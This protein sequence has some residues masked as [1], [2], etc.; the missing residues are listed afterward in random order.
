MSQR[1]QYKKK[2]LLSK[3]GSQMMRIDKFGET[4]SFSIAGRDSYPSF[5]GTLI[6]IMVLSVVI[7]YGLNKYLIMQEYEDTSFQ[8]IKVDNAIGIREEFGY[9]QTNL[10]YFIFFTDST[11]LP[12]P[13][14]DLEGY[15]ELRGVE[16]EI[17]KSSTTNVN[18]KELNF[19]P[20]TKNDLKTNFFPSHDSD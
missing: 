2:N 9:D 20:C 17:E 1:Q 19:R 11:L 15:I 10:N 4:A 18:Q 8:S 13:K 3:I 16:L 6:S 5:C 12:I 14:E 7:P